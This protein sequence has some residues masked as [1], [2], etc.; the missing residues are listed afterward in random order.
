MSTTGNGKIFLQ[1]ASY[2]D[3]QLLPTLRDCIE[4]SD[5][6]ENLVFSISWQHSTEDSWDNMDEF[7]DDPRFKIIDIDYNESK[8]ACWARNKLQQ[9]YDGE[10]YTLQLD[11]HHRFIKGWDTE[12]INMLRDL[13]TNGFSKPLITSYISSFNPETYP[14]GRTQV[15]WQMNFDRF[16]PEGAIFFL[17]ATIPNWENLTEPVR[18]R[19][20]SAH[21]AFTLGQFVHEVPHDPEYYF[22]GEEISIAVRSYTWGYD[23]FHPHKIIAWHEYTRKGRTKQWDDDKTWGT[24]NSNSHLRNRKLFEMDGLSKDIDFGIYDFGTVRTLSDYEKFAGI[25]FKKRAV[26]KYTIDH[27]YAPNPILSDEEFEGSFLSIFKHCIDI[28]KGGLVETDYNFWAVIFENDKGETIHRK[29][30]DE[31]EI[32]GFITSPDPF[33]KIWREFQVEERPTKWI[34]WPHSQSKG[35]MDKIEG[36]L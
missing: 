7:K 9:Q 29:D 34:V 5:N 22:H 32:R 35:W 23:I 28:H 16:I 3:P 33:A 20:Y 25:S 2:R 6:P 26:Q 1:I 11:S 31:K 8:G 13:Q 21:F 18:G 30:C 27:K 12:L 17:P 14:E 24:K 4:N 36:K 10:E 15:P 19:F